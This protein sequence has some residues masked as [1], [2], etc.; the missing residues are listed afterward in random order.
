[1]DI[2]RNLNK[3]SERFI[4]LS[5]YLCTY[6]MV[7]CFGLVSNLLIFPKRQSVRMSKITNDG[8]AQD[9]L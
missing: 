6:S 4:S 8:L 7:P 9:A 5:I 1:M 2:V 3:S